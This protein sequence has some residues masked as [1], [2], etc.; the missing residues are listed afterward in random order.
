MSTTAPTVNS[1]LYTE[2]RNT[3]GAEMHCAHLGHH[4]VTLQSNQSWYQ[5][6]DIW[7]FIAAS[8]PGIAGR[9]IQGVLKGDVDSGRLSIRTLPSGPCGDLMLSSSSHPGDGQFYPFT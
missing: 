6:G 3:S 4:G 7:A 1:C 8:R 2:I 9:R 5:V